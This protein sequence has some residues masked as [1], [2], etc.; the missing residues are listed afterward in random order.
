MDVLKD[1]TT[2][3]LIVGSMALVGVLVGAGVTNRV[4]Y[5]IAVRKEAQDK[6]R[7]REEK[8][9]ELVS[10]VIEHNQW[11]GA[12]RFFAIAGQGSLPYLSPMTKIE[13]IVSTY[14]PELEG[15]LRQFASESTDY[16]VWV[17]DRGQKRVLNEPGYERLDGYDDVLT[18]YLSKS[19]EFL[20]TLKLFARREFQ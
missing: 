20:V 4:N 14:F 5:L 12:L 15:L 7:K 19:A 10:A 2:V 1:A 17:L 16:E 3:S 9:E 8:F 6:K 11:F 13:A 18:K